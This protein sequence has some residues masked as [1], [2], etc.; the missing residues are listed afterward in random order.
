MVTPKVKD[1][2]VL[3]NYELLIIYENGEKK[4]YDM[5]PNF[6]FQVYKQLEDIKLFNTVHSV[7]ETIEWETGIDIAPENLYIDS[8]S[9]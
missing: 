2:K 1:V 7:G 3:E 6:K 4:I 5:K 9:I 8:K